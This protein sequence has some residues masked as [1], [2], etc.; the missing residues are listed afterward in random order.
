MPGWKGWAVVLGGWVGLTLPAAWAQDPP[1][2]LRMGYSSS[3]APPWGEMRGG[4]VAGGIHHD[5]GQALARRLGWTLEFSRIPQLQSAARQS[6]AYVLRFADLLCGMHPS[7]SPNAAEFHWSAPLFEIGD[8][9]VGH[10]ETAS[11]ASLDAL[12]A[13]SLVGTVRGYRYPTLEAR[14]ARGALRR[15]DAP[16]QGS[17]LRK[18]ALRRTPVAVVSVQSLDWHLR[19]HPAAALAAWRLPVQS[20]QYHCA[21][22]KG[23]AIDVPAVQEALLALKREGE[24]ER[25]LARYAPR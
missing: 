9:L 13:G 16:D 4:A 10:I 21:L 14:F 17:L 23:A 20:A 2:V 11:P 5:V 18:L 6:G 1:A 15:E 12:P 8:V 19:Q 22:P 24:L 3:W 25:I 7:W